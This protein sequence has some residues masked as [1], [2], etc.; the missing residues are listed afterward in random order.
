M[1]I[2]AAVMAV[3]AWAAGAGLARASDQNG[4]YARVASVQFEPSAS[5]VSS[6]TRVQIG[7][8]FIIAN[9]PVGSGDAY[10]AAVTGV[11]YYVCPAGKE[12][13]C[14]MEWTDIKNAAGAADCATWG[15]RSLVPVPGLGVVRQ[16]ASGSADMYPIAMGVMR[17]ANGQCPKLGGP[18]A[19]DL[20]ASSADLAGVAADL[21]G[22]LR[23]G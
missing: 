10:S 16:S 3:A 20:G 6:A 1:R 7:G 11:V 2:L 18:P 23:V 8:T 5:D 19:G 4:V 21:G 14:R 22:V 12:S 17:T 13:V 9:G 15:S